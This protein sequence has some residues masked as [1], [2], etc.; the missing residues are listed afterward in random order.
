VRGVLTDIW[1]HSPFVWSKHAPTLHPRKVF[2]SRGLFGAPLQNFRK[3]VIRMVRLANKSFTSFGYSQKS[4]FS[5]SVRSE[6]RFFYMAAPFLFWYMEHAVGLVWKV[7]VSI[8]FTFCIVNCRSGTGTNS[9]QQS[10]HTFKK[11]SWREKFLFDK[12][13]WKSLESNHETFK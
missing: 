1:R 4:G 10:E 13:S 5:K 2:L 3:W 6:L 8:F 12:K 9:V 11:W 7:S